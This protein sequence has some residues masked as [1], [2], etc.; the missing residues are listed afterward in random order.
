MVRKIRRTYR[1]HVTPFGKELITL[2]LK[3]R[4]LVLLPKLAGAPAQ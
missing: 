3:L 2:G 4:E 1:Y